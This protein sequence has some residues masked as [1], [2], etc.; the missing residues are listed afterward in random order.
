MHIDKRLC[1]YGVLSW[2]TNFGKSKMRWNRENQTL[3][4]ICFVFVQRSKNCLKVR[5][6]FNL[7][8]PDD[9][10]CPEVTIA[11]HGQKE[12]AN[13]NAKKLVGSYSF[14][15][16]DTYHKQNVYIGYDN[17]G[18]AYFLFFAGKHWCIAVSNSI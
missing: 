5:L 6:L 14:I 1:G 3:I 7:F 9:E 17:L 13:S 16:K 15:G 2:K 11:L 8:V 10:A 18:K 12:P 4:L